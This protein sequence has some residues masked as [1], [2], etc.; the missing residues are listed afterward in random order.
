MVQKAE[1]VPA[2]TIFARLGA[3]LFKKCYR[4][5]ETLFWK[6]DGLLKPHMHENKKKEKGVPL[7]M[8]TFQSLLSS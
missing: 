2:E 1:P 5:H 8:M 6:L 3:R 7:Q 4:M